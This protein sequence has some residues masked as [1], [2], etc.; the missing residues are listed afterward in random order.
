VICHRH[1]TAANHHGLCVACLLEDALT[2]E[3]A[4]AVEHKG[5]VFTILV[6]LGGTAASSVFLVKADGA[7]GQLFRMKTWHTAAPRDFLS[8]FERLQRDLSACSSE[9]L[10][11]PLA[12]CLDG[13]GRPAVLSQ[14]NQGL[15]ILE[16]VANGGLDVVHAVACLRT[17]Q[18]LIGRVHERGLVHGA[19]ASGNVIVS[20]HGDFAYLLDF[21]QAALVA[22]EAAAPTGPDAD[23]LGFE[24]LIAAVEALDVSAGPQR[25]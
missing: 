24:R 20:A 17:L 10:A 5:S 2:L 16:R 6:P 1:P 3:P 4:P 14:F 12:A 21:G 23:L 25:P 7:A 8:R 15:P 18:G 22:P 13:T 11:L 9:A 19:I